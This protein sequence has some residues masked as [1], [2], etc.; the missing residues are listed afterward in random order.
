MTRHTPDT[1]SSDPLRPAPMSWARRNCF[2]L[3][4]AGALL[5]TFAVGVRPAAAAEPDPAKV[6]AFEK[7]L[8]VVQS[9]DIGTV[10]EGKVLQLISMG[11]EVA[12]P[13]QVSLALKTYLKSNPTPSPELLL[14]SARIADLAGDFRAAIARYKL[15]LKDARSGA[16]S[17]DVAA[18]MYAV[19][20]DML[21]DTRDAYQHMVLNGSRFRNSIMARKFDAT[22]L[23]LARRKG[24]I[25][26]IANRM[27]LMYND[28]L[29]LEQ[30]KLWRRT[31]LRNLMA[32]IIRP[33]EKHFNALPMLRKILPLIRDREEKARFGL[34][35]AHLEFQAG[36][37]GKEAAAIAK[38]FPP[39]AKAGAAFFAVKPTPATH[40]EVFDVLSARDNWN[41]FLVQIEPKRR[42]LSDT[43]MRLDDKAIAKIF[44]ESYGS[45]ALAPA[46]WVALAAK[47]PGF[48]RHANDVLLLRLTPALT[49]IDQVK[50]QAAGVVGRPTQYAAVLRALASGGR[51]YVAC[52]EQLIKNDGWHLDRTA[53]RALQKDHLWPAF[54]RIYEADDAEFVQARLDY[55][56]RHLA[57]GPLPMLDRS[58]VSGYL[59]HAWAHGGKSPIDRSHMPAV[60]HLFDWVPYSAAERRDLFAPTQKEYDAWVKKLNAGMEATKIL[61]QAQAAATALETQRQAAEAAWKKAQAA[62][63]TAADETAWKKAQAAEKAAADAAAKA[64]A[65]KATAAAKSTLDAAKKRAAEATAAAKRSM[66]DLAAKLGRAN[67]NVSRT[68]QQA[69]LYGMVTEE[70]LKQ[71]G[72]LRDA[73]AKVVNPGVSAAAKPPTP[74]CAKMAAAYRAL[75]KGKTAFPKAAQ[76]AYQ[77]LKLFRSRRTP[78]GAASIEWLLRNRLTVVDTI[79]FQCQ[80]LA[81]QLAFYDPSGENFPVRLV[82][83]TISRGRRDWPH[84]AQSSDMAKIKKLNGVL[85]EGMMQLLGK[86][87]YWPDLFNWFRQTR[88]GRSWSQQGWGQDVMEKMLRDRTLFT[89]GHRAYGRS[90][91]TANYMGLVRY[92]FSGLTKKPEFEPVN[93]FA[94]MYLEEVKK[95]GLVDYYYLSYGG[96]DPTGKIYDDAAVRLAQMK[97][98]TYGKPFRD[99]GEYLNWYTLVLRSSRKRA[100]GL[101]KNLEGVYGKTRFDG[102][103]AGATYFDLT[104]NLGGD[105]ARDDFFAHLSTFVDRANKMPSRQALPGFYSLN[106]V[107][108]ERFSDKEL[109]ILLRGFSEGFRIHGYHRDRSGQMAYDYLIKRA[110]AA[111][112]QKGRTLDLYRIAPYLW[113]IARE[114]RDSN[115]YKDMTAHTLELLKREQWGLA[116]A[117]SAIGMQVVGGL[118][119]EESRN[120]LQAARSRAISNIGGTIPVTR[121]DPRFPI[122][123]AQLAYLGGN[124]VSAWN[125]YIRYKTQVPRMYKDLDPEFVI[126]LI[127]RNTEM[128][129]F[130]QAESMAR[131]MI[132]ILSGLSSRFDPEI[133]AKLYLAYARIAFARKEFPRARAQFE[134]IVAAKEFAATRARYS[135]ELSLAEVDRMTKNFDKAIE[136]LEKL[137]ETEDR[138]L[139]TNALFQLAR[140]KFDQEDYL[141]AMDD[142][143]KVF[144]LNPEHADGRILQGQLYLKLKKLEE[145]KEIDLGVATRQ[146]LIVPGRALK[147]KLE[148]RNLAVVG[149]ATNIQIRAWTSSGDEEFFNLFPF[150][151][152]KTRFEGKVDTFLAPIIKGDHRLQLLGDDEVF[153]DFSETFK[154][155]ANVTT[156]KPVSLTVVTDA[157]MAASSGKL[158]TKKEIEDQRLRRMLKLI[159]EDANIPKV[160]L[161]TVR[162]AN[163][164][165]P[166]NPINIRVTDPD[167]SVTA[168]PDKLIVRAATSSGDAIAAF[169][170]TETEGTSGIFQGAIPTDSAQAAAFASD[171]RE[172]SLPNFTVSPRK[173]PPWVGLPDNIRPKIFGVDLNDNVALG[174]MRIVADVAG[175]RPKSFLLQTSLNRKSYITVGAWPTQITAWDGSPE[176]RLVGFAADDKIDA[177]EYLQYGHLIKKRPMAIGKLKSLGANLSQ[178]NLSRDKSLSQAKLDRE[179]NYVAH[180]RAAFYVAKREKII[181]RLDHKFTPY[182]AKG[183]GGGEPQIEFAI[184]DN[185][186]RTPIGAA[187]RRGKDAPPQEPP[188]IAAAYEKGVHL[189][190][191][192]ITA[193]RR[194]DLR[195]QL[196]R[197]SD[198]PPYFV[199]CPPELLASEHTPKIRQ[200]IYREPQEIEA[201]EDGSQFD[202]AFSADANARVVRL[203]M[204]DFETDAPAINKVT[205]SNAD[206]EKLLPTKTDFSEL[207]KNKVLEIIPGDSIAI[208][209]GDDKTL[210]R[211][212]RTLEE[213]LSATYNNAEVSATFLE[214]RELRGE[215]IAEYIPL[216]R[217]KTGE[218]LVAFFNDPDGDISE[219]VDTL[220]FTA[221]TTEGKP[222]ALKA[223]ETEKHSGIFTAR[224]FPVEGAPTKATEIQVTQGDHILLSYR[225]QE[226]TDPGIPWDREYKVSQTFWQDPEMRVYSVAS[227]EVQPLDVE[228]PRSKPGEVE[229]EDGAPKRIMVISRPDRIDNET[230]VPILVDGPLQVEIIWPTIVLSPLNET[231]IYVQTS[232]GRKKAGIDEAATGD[233]G[234]PPFDITVPGT[235]RLATTPGGGPATG[236]SEEYASVVFKGNSELGDPL[237]EGRFVFGVPFELGVTPDQSMAIEDPDIV[238]QEEEDN[239]LKINGADDIF[240]GFKYTD[241]AG[242]VIWL[243]QR[244]LLRGDPRF[245]V[246]DKKYE[247]ELV[248]IHV[249]ETLFL[250]IDD[251]L[252]DTTDER[253]AVKI[254]LEAA[255]S[256]QKISFDMREMF[257][258]KGEFRGFITPTF[259]EANDPNRIAAGPDLP[260]LYGDTITLTYTPGREREPIVR[261]VQVFKGADGLVLAFTK[262]FKDPQIAVQTQFTIAEALFELAK[263][264]RVLGQKALALREI[265]QGRKLL[266]EAIRDFPNSDVKAQADFLLANLSLE[267]AEDVAEEEKETH[268]LE[269]ISRFTDIVALYSDSPYAP[270]SQYKK[271]LTYEKMGQLDQA[272]EEYVKLSYRYP[273]NELVA[274]T[275]ARLGQYFWK[276][277]KVTK[278][279]SERQEDELERAKL[280]KLAAHMYKTS[281]E[282]FGR[283]G[284][285]FPQHHLAGKTS[286][287]SGQAYMQAGDYEKAVEVFILAIKTYE[288]EKDLIP[289]A[290]YWCADSYTKLPDM[291]EAW[292]MFKRL[293]W[294]YPATKWAKYARGRL[295]SPEMIQ[296]EKTA[297]GE[298]N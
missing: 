109:D 147:V 207:L 27:F 153:Y 75:A 125:L 190:N 285:R 188:T 191:L 167:R 118:L 25:E 102:M 168:K 224:L 9:T 178:H 289:E 111:Y 85:A 72:P 272:C 196:L 88:K 197:D 175:R 93:G 114:R 76:D 234:A 104:R 198:E 35:L 82:Y 183:R 12:R 51:S 22:F 2:A 154:D 134:R 74:L 264:H 260:V 73:L 158:L 217:F 18:R 251:K 215:Q 119:P 47:K 30:E 156:K 259:A 155:L 128:I 138:S 45:R 3:Y 17:S 186:P 53:F 152:S 129:D 83:Q 145:A 212:K 208:L 189:I 294:D 245:D 31:H 180:L 243:T 253:D 150:G 112:L 34:Y 273:D 63:K 288:K 241:E 282:V 206:G 124:F 106:T 1:R 270:K 244:I 187:R 200:A 182:G 38:A 135:A 199:P 194:H 248:G 123:S 80:V 62:E 252:L 165:K 90:S 142:L 13:Y 49:T 55:G 161:S 209:Y 184:D 160:A 98:L 169:A 44:G 164:V 32:D 210:D 232:T 139:R 16:A 54:K 148:D 100:E 50:K 108:A 91:I 274:E 33:E 132:Q 174:D 177:H 120:S 278:E 262:R 192:T 113:K 173:Y 214:Y 39:V 29:P 87:Q 166:G 159:E 11:E 79:D 151:D 179:G 110:F 95:T 5:M 162:V 181:F 239:I 265:A 70:H 277:G 213:N 203:V 66:D 275:I 92:E 205:L 136:R 193:N 115:F 71:T 163:Q 266:T 78:Y 19:Q 185:V 101:L 255:L 237:E 269:A 64:T 146:R 122:Y 84:Y 20:I 240:V 271:A 43:L 23:D 107:P 287:L 280:G 144:L 286:V 296:V 171:S 242:K 117:Y 4:I 291:V 233:E 94:A 133:Q 58:A 258:H 7:L 297:M 202:I 60:L 130:T 226:N 68:K 211:Q 97:T 284:A 172:G 298:D 21:G 230:P 236:A 57:R 238:E 231:E 256:G 105:R 77:G 116:A 229:D 290:M 257:E 10:N 176:L 59:A 219:G 81:D 157:D 222:V 26:A 149:S 89:H 235:I 8:G 131:D 137:I 246:L 216:V 247:D 281:A 121:D 220:E 28:R 56:S 15:Y 283:L 127:N 279:E 221:K 254:E 140:V 126:W 42:V 61:R 268:Y 267:I 67:S 103:A 201:N 292:R 37:K 227:E 261:A 218:T 170:L 36:A 86:K 293:T 14:K 276:K 99:S 65:A 263:K 69:E 46:D 40:K 228:P 249:G 204:I 195:L 295:A 143:E 225:D 52:V 223:Y 41:V 48:L 141:D 250:R 6:E 96:G 24:D